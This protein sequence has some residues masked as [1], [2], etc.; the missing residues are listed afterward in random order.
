MVRA[1]TVG[2]VVART[3]TGTRARTHTLIHTG[4]RAHSFAGILSVVAGNY[5]ASGAQAIGHQS[6]Q[7]LPYNYYK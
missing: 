4:T 6:L 7:S 1:S 5:A 2:A 3:R